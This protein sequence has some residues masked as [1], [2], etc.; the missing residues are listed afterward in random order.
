[1]FGVWN[2]S[3]FQIF[4]W[5]LKQIE[6]NYDY[7]FF[8][9]VGFIWTKYLSLSQRAQN[10]FS[11]VLHACNDTV[12]ERFYN[13]GKSQWDVHWGKN[14]TCHRDCIFIYSEAP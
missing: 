6:I 8:C 14:V 13:M 9:L 7:G 5:L 11:S 12:G 4:T 10:Y 3:V 1:M 2:V